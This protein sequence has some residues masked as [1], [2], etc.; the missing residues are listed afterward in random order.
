MPIIMRIVGYR[1]MVIAYHIAKD[2]PFNTITRNWVAKYL[3]KW[4]GK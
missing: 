2:L 3:M 4:F 1:I